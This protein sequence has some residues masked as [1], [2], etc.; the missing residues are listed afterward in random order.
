MNNKQVSLPQAPL[1]IAAAQAQP[2]SGDVTANIARTVE[3]T[4]IAAD[5]GAKLV[6]FPEKFL[7]GYEPDLIAGD[8]AKYAFDEHDA[9]LEPIREVCRERE[10]AVIVG[11]ATRGIGNVDGLHISSLVFN[12]AGELIESYHKQHLYSGE[13]KIYQAGLQGC[14]LEIDGWRLALGVCYD[15]GFPEH[16]R[17]AAVNGAHAYLVSAL[18]SVKTGYHQSRIWFPARAFDNTLYV[19][20][21][22]HVGTTGGWETCGASAIWGPYGDVV[23]EASRDRE[24]V[25]TALLDPTVLADVRER[26]TMLADFKAHVAE[27]AGEYVVHRLD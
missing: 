9:R 6:V 8:P 5:R 2:V 24:E 4:N 13:T 18:F 3:L 20:L 16:A 14:M 21:S 22:N 23:T 11:A 7:S 12:R 15:S 10:I 17:N 1:R 27:T 26:E 25:I 19:L